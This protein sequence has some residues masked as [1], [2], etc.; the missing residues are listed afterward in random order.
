MTNRLEIT[1]PATITVLGGSPTLSSL[2]VLPPGIAVSGAAAGTVEVQVQAANAGAVLSASGIAGA[3]VSSGGGS[4]AITGTAAEVNAALASL[5]ITESALASTDVLTLTAS[6]AGLLPGQTDIAVDVVP[7]TGP[8]FVA[9][10]PL[11]TIQPDAL[12]TLPFLTLA[13]PVA[14]DLA[15]MG[16]GREETLNL[17]LGVPSGVLF[18]P[19]FT[20]A[21]AISA[22]GLGTGEIILSFTAD[23]I[24]AVNT[25]LAGLEFAGPALAGNEHL[26]FTANNLSGVLPAAETTGNVYLNI[27][28]TPGLNGVFA[29]GSQTLI[30]GG[31][32]LAGTTV[33]SNTTALLG[34]I[35]GSGSVE[36]TPTGNLELP[37]DALFLG[38]TSLDFGTINAS[39]L[40]LNGNLLA[41]SGAAFSGEEWL[42]PSATL[43]FDGLL[44]SDGA[45]AQDFAQAVSLSAGAVL[46]GNGTL[47][48]GNFSESGMITGPGTIFAGSGET[49]TIAAGSVGGGADL[50][51]GPGGVMVLGPVEPLYGIFNATP[52]T[53]DNSVTLN[54][55][56]GS[57]L[58]PVGGE[59]AGTLGGDG[60]AF[61]INGPQVLSGSIV[62]FAPGDELVFPGLSGLN[63]LAS[64]RN[65]ISIAGEDGNGNSVVYTFGAQIPTGDVLITGVDAG[66]DDV[67]EL[68]PAAAAMTETGEL[69][70]SAN[71]AQPLQGLELQL[72][73]ATTQS[74][75]LTLSVH[76]GTLSDGIVASGATITLT[77]GNVAAMNVELAGLSYTGTGAADALTIVSGG[78]ALENQNFNGY[79]DFALIP[80]LPGTINSGAVAAFSEAQIASFGLN[81]GLGMESA[82][83]AAGELWVTGTTDFE[84]LIQARGVSG[85]SLLIDGGGTAI[86]NDSASVSLGG[87]VT[88]GDAGGAGTLVIAGQDFTSAGNLT[89]AAAANGAGS[90]AYVLGSLG[91][92]GT[93]NAG[94]AGAAVLELGGSLSAGAVS[95]GSA[96]TI[97]GIGTAS[98]NFG[99]V[100]G[101][102]T[103]ILDGSAQAQASGVLLTGG[104]LSLGGT[105]SLNVGGL[106]QMLAGSSIQIGADNLLEAG[107][108][109]LW[110]CALT[111]AGTLAAAGTIQL[112]NSVT[113]NGGTITASTIQMGETLS[114]YGVA[115]AAA[116][117]GQGVILAQ[118]GTLILGGSLSNNLEF[119]IGTSAA[120]DLAGGFGGAAIAFNGPAALLTLDDPDEFTSG[121]SNFTATDAVDLVG[122][123]P[124]LVS[125][126]AIVANDPAV[127]GVAMYVRDSLGNTIA[128]SGVQI[129]PGQPGLSIVSDGAGGSLV[130]LGGELP[131]YA[132]GTRLLTPHGYRPVEDL[133]PGDPLITASGA[134][135]P[136]RWIGR[137]TLDL[138]QRAAKAAF[139]VVILPGAFGPGLP[140]RLLRLSPLHCV[141]A[142]GVLIPATHLVNG[143]T[144]IRDTTAKATTYYHVELDRHDIL[145]AEGLPCESYFDSGN[146]GGLYHETG[147]RSPA[148]KPFAESVTRGA[149][150]A[151]VRR[152]LHS[153]ALDAGFSLTYWPSLRAV[154]AGQ[155]ALPEMIGRTARFVFKSPV[156][157]ITLIS[158]V[159]SPADT[160]PQ[161]EDRR[162]L[163][164]C[165]SAAGGIRFNAGFYPRGPGDAGNWAGKVAALALDKPSAEVSLPLAAIV[166]SWVKPLDPARRGL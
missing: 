143:A 22:T 5:E 159:A 88:I 52:L 59:Y 10:P 12:D 83:L 132:R 64:G 21:S 61:V 87:G 126:S 46:T 97:F 26:T 25:L 140:A 74:L 8:V 115:E 119:G 45:E 161:S 142:D 104:T 16:L 124:S 34:N 37:D 27:V 105:S 3:T 99:N 136:V 75:S 107:T 130:T 149:R 66:G 131:C 38:G 138:G 133:K 152:R 15:A 4:L 155:S 162:E 121:V 129:A 89:L 65:T 63:I 6:E 106:L 77:A 151:A 56:G 160:N 49:L 125:F 146:R 18:L 80:V 73:T 78:A 53:I 42:E 139:P 14:S 154:G 117:S 100:T 11:V 127:Q 153:I 148:R 122:V 20:D 13:D 44:T 94:A 157:E 144:I 9:P 123:A 51:V 166:Q 137:R 134:A 113:L 30:E 116:I 109:E 28:G 86:F 50:A 147:R 118:G 32:T 54:F 165:L 81:G 111:D 58:S 103:I 39:E 108:Q 71:V 19:G 135:K 141:Y 79:N 29:A 2:G 84:D 114:G 48:A 91:L 68:R 156:R 41:A 47:L 120:L 92:A 145:L 158:G 24:G 36:I 90:A 60:G 1:A 67:V 35:S 17:T 110:G 163:G 43:D 93:L 164:I 57:G 128:M 96:G 55:L 23:D 62:G 101:S 31:E 112:D 76:H 7:S 33:I 72:F 70:F 98:A 95:L 85:T 102:G 150:L 82:P 40:G 69:A